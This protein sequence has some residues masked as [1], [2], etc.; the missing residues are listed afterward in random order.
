[1]NNTVTNNENIPKKRGRKPKPKNIDIPNETTP[2]IKTET[3]TNIENNDNDN[4]DNIVL[5]INECSTNISNINNDDTKAETPQVAKKRGRKPKGGKIIKQSNYF[6]N[7]NES[8][9]NVIL[10]LKCFMKDLHTNNSESIIDGF[11]FPN[12]ICSLK[13][14]NLENNNMN[15]SMIHSNIGNICIESET[16]NS[17]CKEN[18]HVLFD[19]KNYNGYDGYDGDDDETCKEG[20]FRD[21]WKKIK[22]I[23]QNLHINNVENNR[24]AC[25]WDTHKFDNPPV[26][27]PKYYMDDTYHVYGCFC[28]PECAVAYLMQE[29]LDSSV[30]F[31]RYQL[32]NNIYSKIYEYNKNIKPAPNPYYLLDK[33]YGNMNIQEYRA[34]LSSERLFLITDKPLTRIMPELHEDNNDFIVN[35]KIIQN[36]VKF[37]KRTKMTK[38]N[39]LSEH[40]GLI[41]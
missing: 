31:E 19:N 9:T 5:E 22:I 30:K 10:H 16:N 32:L 35:N 15:N 38:T 26:Y 8:K 21:I 27:I 33:Y 7:T 1:M 37:D 13:Y 40:F 41:S 12:N 6:P 4:N 39:I 34:L 2:K 18:N 20:N 25:F 23:K 28:S 11:S 24:S 3:K 29:N 36:N 14:D 17:C